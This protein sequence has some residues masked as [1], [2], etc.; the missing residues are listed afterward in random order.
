MECETHQLDQQGSGQ[1]LEVINV[2]ETL[3]WFLL[4][5]NQNALT[6]HMSFC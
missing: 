1:R 4:L 6:A 3:D 5:A 2:G